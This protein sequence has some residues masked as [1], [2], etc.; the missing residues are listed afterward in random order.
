MKRMAGLLAFFLS[1][2]GHATQIQAQASCPSFSAHSPQATFCSPA[3]PCELGQ[4]GCDSDS[5]CLSGICSPLA[6]A[7]FG[8]P[9]DFGI[10]TAA[11]CA[12]ISPKA[13]NASACTPECPCP[14]GWGG[15]DA[16]ED[17]RPGAFCAENI[18]R[19]ADLPEWFGLCTATCPRF[20]VEQPLAAYCSNAECK[21]SEGQGDCDSN[22]ECTP[23]NVCR[24]DVGKWAQLPAEWDVCEPPFNPGT[25]DPDYCTKW[26]CGEGEGDCDANA[27]CKPG[28]YCA[29]GIGASVG[30]PP[31]YGVCT[32]LR[33]PLTV[34]VSRDGASG[35]VRLPDGVSCS[36]T[37]TYHANKNTE[38]ALTANLPSTSAIE[39][40]GCT[41]ISGT[42]CFVQMNA[43]KTVSA[44]IRSRNCPAATPYCCER[45]PSGACDLCTRNRFQ[46]LGE[47]PRG[48]F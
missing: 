46:C 17:C 34:Q 40:S 39:W 7:R 27:D 25:P 15:C 20:D 10:C 8:L 42:T 19:L 48:S 12:P 30:L 35:S 13:P 14:E 45:A 21:C 31:A 6:G 24:Q 32:N 4:G 28:F 43:Q 38:I 44:S 36:G 2:L 26:G 3:C 33:F 5:D 1:V 16:N 29:E 41:R 9:A 23:G 18:G 22:S 37:C 47:R 11:F